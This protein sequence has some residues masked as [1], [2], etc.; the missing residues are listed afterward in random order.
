MEP[1]TVPG[2]LDSLAAIRE[3][4]KA[5]AA[6]AGLDRKAAYRLRLAVDEIATNIATHGY[7]EAGLEGTVDL[8]ADIEEKA[9]VIYVEDTGVTYDPRGCEPP[10]DLDLPLEQR[11]M[12]GLG[13]FLAVRG[14]DKLLYERIG[15]RNRHT[16]VVNRT[17]SSSEE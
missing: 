10:D 14:V 9:L 1:L 15:E 2:T 13:V 8:R 12:G 7:A 5:A 3:Y 16:L 6:A 11:Q 17:A 4:V